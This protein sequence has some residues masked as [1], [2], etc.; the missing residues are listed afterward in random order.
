M[1]LIPRTVIERA[2]VALRPAPSVTLTVN[3]ELPGAVG[4]PE[5]VPVEPARLRPA[6][7]DPALTVQVYGGTP[8][9]LAK[10]AE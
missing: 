8:P 10:V 5:R 4:L 3:D 7:R 2:L 9:D 1:V 6:G